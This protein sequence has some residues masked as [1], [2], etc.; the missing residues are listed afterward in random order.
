[1]FAILPLHSSVLCSLDHDIARGV[2]GL[3]DDFL[4]NLGGFRSA[5]GRL[6]DHCVSGTH[7]SD[8]WDED[9]RD[10][11]VPRADNQTGSQRLV[12]FGHLSG[13]NHKWSFGTRVRD[14]GFQ[15]IHDVVDFLD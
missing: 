4:E 7:C 2:A 5:L 1:M 8:E 3:S 14:P 13:L 9:S 10:R 11:V 6:D 12:E 15:I